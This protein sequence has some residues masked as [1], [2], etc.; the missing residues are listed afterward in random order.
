[1]NLVFR[2]GNGL[3][4]VLLTIASHVPDLRYHLFS[5]PTLIKN[6]HTFEGRPPRIVVKLE[7]DHLIVFPLTGTLYS[8]YGYW[9]DCSTRE[10]ACAVLAP[11]QLPKKPAVDINDYHCAAGHSNKMLLRK[12][13]EK[14]GIVLEGNLLESRACSMA[15][16]IRKGIKQSMHTRE[17]KKLGRAIVDLNGPKVVE[18]LGRTR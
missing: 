2:S 18:S 7:S 1:M 8:I 4:Q 3:V 14:Q 13:A 12:T 6:D 16:V 10:N 17:D 11:G 9:V 5:L 15:K